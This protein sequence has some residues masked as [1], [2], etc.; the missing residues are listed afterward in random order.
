V[1]SLLAALLLLL[2]S[3]ALAASGPPPGLAGTLAIVA[4]DATSVTLHAEQTGGS[5]VT[6][7]VEHSCYEGAV[8]GGGEK[9][10]FVGSADMTFNIAPRTYHGHL[11][12]PTNC[13]ATLNFYYSSSRVMVLAY[14]VTLP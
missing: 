4:Q 5:P 8:Y 10:S 7:K 3:Q 1:R 2:P 6:L 12:T 11:V 9:V 13:W 14:Q